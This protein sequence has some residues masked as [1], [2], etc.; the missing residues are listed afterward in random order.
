MAM[1]TVEVP[2]PLDFELSRD[3]EREGISATEHA[4]LLLCLASAMLGENHPTP[5]RNA[6]RAF[7]AAH[8]L[9]AAQVATALEELVKICAFHEMS[10]SSQ[11]IQEA[12]ASSEGIEGTS[13]NP[14]DILRRWRNS[15]VHALADRSVEPTTGASS[16]NNQP[17]NQTGQ[18]QGKPRRKSALGRYARISY[19][20]EEYALDKRREITHEEKGKQ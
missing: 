2:A 11:A 19:G 5:F 10:E 17:I 7:L 13:A 6:V 4:T 1:L 15:I 8:S 18:T 9:D 20:S 12:G 14:S 16:S 3:A